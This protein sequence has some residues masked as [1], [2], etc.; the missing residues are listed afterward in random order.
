MPLIEKYSRFYK[1]LLLL[2][3]YIISYSHGMTYTLSTTNILDAVRV[4]NFIWNSHFFR[5]GTIWWFH[6]LTLFKNSPLLT[7]NHKICK[8]KIFKN[9]TLLTINHKIINIKLIQ[10]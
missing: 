1:L 2:D 5:T 3:N 9:S 7:I 4:F 8:N 6:I 10:I